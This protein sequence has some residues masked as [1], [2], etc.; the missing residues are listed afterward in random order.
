MIS[1]SELYAIYRTNPIICTDTR[2][3]EKDCLFFA[4][5][6]DNFNG[7]KFAIDAIEKGAAFAIVD[8][9]KLQNSDHLLVVEDV[10]STLQKLA[11]H[12]RNQFN[13]PFIGITGSNGAGSFNTEEEKLQ[14]R[15]SRIL[16]Q[17]DRHAENV[18]L[19]PT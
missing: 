8:D 5:K 4:L 2:K 15:E 11:Q 14:A 3:I 12:H 16:Q 19:V 17:K 18:R 7:N 6:G 13:I 10:L 9:P 1:I